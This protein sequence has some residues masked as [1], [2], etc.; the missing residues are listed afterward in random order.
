MRYLLLTFLILCAFQVSAENLSGK[1]LQIKDNVALVKT[2]DGKKVLVVLTENTYYRKKK[3][4]KKDKR[5]G[6]T[7]EFYLPLIGKDE[8]VVLS[9]DPQTKDEKTG[10][11]MASDVLSIID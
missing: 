4:L 9:Y 7:A 3:I 2:A 1:V 6:A 8:R 5:T 11:I 10:A